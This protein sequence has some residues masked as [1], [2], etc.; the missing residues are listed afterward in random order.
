[1]NFKT[2]FE[3]LAKGLKYLPAAISAGK[4]VKSTVIAL[5]DLAVAAK[6]GTVTQEQID[7][8]DQRLDNLIERF[9]RPI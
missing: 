4:N 6:D 5:R 1:V 9:N 8:V 3:T 2:V 7:S